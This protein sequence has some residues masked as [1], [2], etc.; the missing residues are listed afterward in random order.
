M[1]DLRPTSQDL[2]VIDMSFGH[3]GCEGQLGTRSTRWESVS[4]ACWTTR[5]IKCSGGKAYETP[6]AG[7]PG[8]SRLE[9][10]FGTTDRAK[11]RATRAE[12][13]RSAPLSGPAAPEVARR[14]RDLPWDAVPNAWKRK[15]RYR[16]TD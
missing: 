14:V 5:G 3:H 16:P 13:T 7:C 1:S 11:W 2:V 12:R 4:S 6:A 9:K 10:R 8:R 15:R